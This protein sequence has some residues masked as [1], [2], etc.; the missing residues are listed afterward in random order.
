M[1][2]HILANMQVQK[3]VAWQVIHWGFSFRPIPLNQD[4][5]FIWF[6][7]RE[8]LFFPLAYRQLERPPIATTIN[9]PLAV[10]AAATGPETD[11]ARLARPSRVDVGVGV[12]P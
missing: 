5:L 7:Q 2:H 9:Q 4:F 12:H 3:E 11:S 10:K 8:C 1:C 6:L